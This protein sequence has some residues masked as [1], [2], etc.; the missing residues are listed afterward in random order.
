ML[1]SRFRVLC[2]NSQWN[3]HVRFFQ[4]LRALPPDEPCFVLITHG[5][6]HDVKVLDVLP[7]EV[8]AFYVMDRGYLDFGRL[9]RFTSTARQRAKT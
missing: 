7:I 2:H 3:Q 4:V 5:K 6:T 1:T 9:H 8:G